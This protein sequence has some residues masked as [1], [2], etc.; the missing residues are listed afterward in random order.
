MPRRGIASIQ[1]VL[2]SIIVR[3]YM[4]PGKKGKGPTM[5][6]F[7][8]ENLYSGT[9]KCFSGDLGVYFYQATVFHFDKQV[10][11][12]YKIGAKEW[13]ADIC[14]DEPRLE[15]VLTKMKTNDESTISRYV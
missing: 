7:M 12:E 9:E 3:R 11:C 1:R 13:A 14:C 15:I 10:V 2:L 5:S 8:G 6:M 4:N